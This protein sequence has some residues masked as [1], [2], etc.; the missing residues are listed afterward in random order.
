MK[1]I[2]IYITTISLL[3][4]TS[5]L[6]GSPTHAQDNSLPTGII[7]T[8]WK[9]LEI[10]RSPQDILSTTNTNVTLTFDP[11]GL[12]KGNSTCNSY[13]APYQTAAGQSLTLGALVSTLRAC[14]DTSLMDLETEYYRAL[15]AVTT[16]SFDGATL[17][18]FYNNGASILKF[19]T[20]SIPGMPKTGGFGIN[21]LVFPLAG[22][23]LLLLLF[24]VI[25]LAS[26]HIARRKHPKQP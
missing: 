19:G 24:T 25:S 7:G 2:L 10:Q 20:T 17:Q 26:L 4:S 23:L 3:T 18:L 14:V 9:L 22:L 5:F 8:E 6:S 12:A 16:Y 13:S 15:Q 11:Q 1:R 21:Q